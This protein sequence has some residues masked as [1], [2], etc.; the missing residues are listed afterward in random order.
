MCRRFR[1]FPVLALVLS[2]SACQDD[3]SITCT[4]ELVSS[5]TLTIVDAQTG[6]PVVDAM[7]SFQIDGG[8]IRSAEAPYSE[9]R[10]ALAYEEDGHF[11]VTIEATGYESASAEYDVAGGQC[12]VEGV[13][14]TIELVPVSAGG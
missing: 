14:D 2:A 1:S 6:E 12:H 7:V 8:E 4:Q 5:V 10:F 13:G 9:G 3:G 11:E